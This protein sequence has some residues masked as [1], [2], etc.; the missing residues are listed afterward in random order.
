MAP[1]LLRNCASNYSQWGCTYCNS[2]WHY[3][4]AFE[5]IFGNM[6]TTIYDGLFVYYSK[7]SAEEN[8]LVKRRKVKGQQ[9]EIA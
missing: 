8:I 7:Q 1:K 2:K 9:K 6:V 4:V 5:V 3:S